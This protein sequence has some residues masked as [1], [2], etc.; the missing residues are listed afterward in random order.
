MRR[1]HHRHRGGKMVSKG[2]YGCGFIP[3]LLCEGNMERDK[4]GFSKFMKKENAEKEWEERDII[5]KIDPH[6]QYS[7][8]PSR[9]CAFNINKASS[10]N[11]INSCGEQILSN[12]N[13][14]TFKDDIK[15]KYALLQ[16]PVGGVALSKINLNQQ[17][18]PFILKSFKQLFDGLIFMHANSFYHLDI[19]TDNIVAMKNANN[20]YN[21]RYIDFGLSRS[22][23][24]FVENDEAFPFGDYL[25]WP[26]EF[27]FLSMRFKLPAV[28]DAQLTRAMKIHLDRYYLNS[29]FEKDK[30]K[31][32]NWYN[33]LIYIPEGVH[34][35]LNG[36]RL[37]TEEMYLEI[38]KK[39]K[40]SIETKGMKEALEDILEKV[41]VYSLGITLAYLITAS[42][43]VINRHN[44]YYTLGP[45]GLQDPVTKKIKNSGHIAAYDLLFSVVR[46]MLHYDP[47]ERLSARDALIKYREAINA[48]IHDETILKYNMKKH[49]ISVDSSPTRKRKRNNISITNLSPIGK[50]NATMK[51][52]RLK[53]GKIVG[54]GAYGCGFIPALQCFE[55]DE[56]EENTFTKLM[57]THDAKIEMSMVEHIRE[58]DPRQEFSLYARTICLPNEKKIS[59]DDG[60]HQCRASIFKGA[61]IQDYKFLLTSGEVSLLQ[62][63]IGGEDLGHVKVPKERFGQFIASFQNIMRGL[64]KMHS[65]GFYHFDIK[66]DNILTLD[67]DGKYITRFIDFGLSRTAEE[68][69]KDAEYPINANYEIWPYEFRL[70]EHYNN[71]EMLGPKF[72]DI[73]Y[74]KGQYDV[75]KDLPKTYLKKS[76]ITTDGSLQVP[77]GVYFYKGH[78]TEDNAHFKNI[79][80]QIATNIQ[81]DGINALKKYL[82][83]VDVFSLGLCMAWVFSRNTGYF[84]KFDRVQ[85]IDYKKQMKPVFDH[86]IIRY[87]SGFFQL[88][89]K[90]MD[91]NPHQRLT[92]RGAL[93]EFQRYLESVKDIGI[94][95]VSPT[96][97]ID[98]ESLFESELGV[99]SSNPR[100]IIAGENNNTSGNIKYLSNRSF[101]STSVNSPSNS[102]LIK[103]L[104]QRM[105]KMAIPLSNNS[106]RQYYAKSIN[107]TY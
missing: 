14:N 69:I 61:H 25:Y 21:F 87:V 41:D 57:G 67:K 72:I 7:V 12:V 103:N 19:K 43:K 83:K 29:L 23:Q 62:T 96:D 33:G 71:M 94:I 86:D 63:P 91:P 53:G 81:T 88:I 105:R 47:Y 76:D 46:G 99:Y 15:T 45:K 77:S 34:Y 74:A 80:S 54:Q 78:L 75:F 73:L 49:N 1:T 22:A 64:H 79:F 5:S 9:K 38:Y 8:Y 20:Q 36:N 106:G 30:G 13:V 56:R 97:I 60:L 39:F 40:E 31:N 16:M 11:D 18:A 101:T 48:L 98:V 89:Q 100:S 42:M 59:P 35:D 104:Q 51:R 50:N 85:Y 93:I 68:L 55:D 84:Y 90:M 24:S 52:P 28:D 4:D 70:Y 65:K 17:T 107:S 102:E 37:L 92:A 58:I 95:S 27:A 26:L 44:S 3:A 10:F 66:A 2:A 32:P 6:Y 82:E